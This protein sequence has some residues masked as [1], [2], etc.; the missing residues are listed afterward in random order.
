MRLEFTEVATGEKFELT[1][2]EEWNEDTSYSWE[3]GNMSCDCNRRMEHDR[4]RGLSDEEVWG[5]EAAKAY[6]C[7]DGAYV[8]CVVDAGRCP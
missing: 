7:G 5:K 4:A 6:P 8:M 3:E 2:P 1:R